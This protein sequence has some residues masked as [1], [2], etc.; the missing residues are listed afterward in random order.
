MRFPIVLLFAACASL[1]LP[2]LSQA[3]TYYVAPG[4]ST[5]NSCTTSSAPCPT[6]SGAIGKAKVAGDII[7]IAAGTYKEN[8]KMTYAG[9]AGNPITLRGHDGSG[10]PATAS[11]DPN[12]PTG[13]RPNSG[14]LLNGSI[15]ISANYVTVDCIHLLGGGVSISSGLSGGSIVN[16]E[17]DGNGSATPGAG[18]SFS[19]I[20]STTSTNFSKNFIFTTNFIHGMS[21][22][23]FGMCSSC[24]FSDNEIFALAGDEPGS[25]HDYIDFWGI[26]S[27]IS[28]NYMHGNTCNSCNGYDCH[29]DCIQ[30]WNTTGNG[31]EVSQNNTFTRNICFNHHE[32]VIMQDNAGNG[33]IGGWTV[34]NNVFAYG[35]YD[36]GSGNLCAAGTVHPWCWVFEDGSL[37]STTFSNNTCVAGT[38][39]FRSTKG[40]AVFDDNIYFTLGSTTTIYDTS[41]AT[42]TGNNNLYYAASGKFSGG[43]FTGDLI[44]KDPLFVSTGSGGTA[45]CIGCNYNIQA[46]SPA[47]DAGMSTAPTIVVD[48]LD[49]ARPQGKGYD[50]G[51]YEYNSG[52]KVQPAPPQNLT[53]V[54]H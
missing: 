32:G 40:N 34:S 27:T 46:T 51:A 38:M 31:T 5:L 23:F 16:N 47:I 49:T 1:L 35:P 48:L 33:D 9:S 4:G 19:G 45:Q 29:M 25:D 8:L 12:S 53:G 15:S 37:G 3:T 14:A 52:S 43:T 30:A 36:D 17:I 13:A 24:T 21:V 28:H 42:V 20:G 11:V 22:G 7:Q 54:A 50:I 18:I 6:I 2:A 41:S 10:C 44:N 26:G 39:G